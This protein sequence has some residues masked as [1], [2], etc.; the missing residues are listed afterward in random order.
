MRPEDLYKAIQRSVLVDQKA[1]EYE[2]QKTP[3]TT[4]VKKESVLPKQPIQEMYSE[5]TFSVDREKEV[6]EDNDDFISF[7]KIMEMHKNKNI[8]NEQALPQPKV[9]PIQEQT[10]RTNNNDLQ[11]LVSELRKEIKK[12]IK[13]EYDNLFEQKIAEFHEKRL[14]KE[15]IQIKVGNTVFSGELKP[16]PKKK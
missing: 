4:P 7:D 16:M 5:N 1:K 10:S 12:I 9:K 14:I 2:N 15:N 13:E 11:N 8:I 6:E 3:S